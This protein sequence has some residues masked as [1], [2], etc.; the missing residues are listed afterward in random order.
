MYTHMC[1]CRGVIRI[2]HVKISK[3]I[4]LEQW[5]RKLTFGAQDVS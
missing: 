2:S 4:S 1:V 3:P 5:L